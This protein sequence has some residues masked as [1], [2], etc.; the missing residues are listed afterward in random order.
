M[1]LGLRR[2]EESVVHYEIKTRGE[3]GHVAAERIV[4]IYRYLQAVQV[5]AIVRL[6]EFLHVSILVA[7]HLLGGE[8]LLAE[9]FKGLVAYRIHHVTAVLVNHRATL[10]IQVYIL[11]LTIH[12]SLFTR[13]P[14]AYSS[15]ISSFIQS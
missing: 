8:S 3:V 14:P 4:G 1:P 6:E 10:L 5:Q 13:D 9:A 11:F 7:L 15:P 12:F 2:S